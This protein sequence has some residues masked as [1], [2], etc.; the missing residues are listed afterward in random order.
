MESPDE[1][2]LSTPL[3]A[4]PPTLT[5]ELHT[6]PRVSSWEGRG[7]SM[8]ITESTIDPLKGT[9]I[10]LTDAHLRPHKTIGTKG[11]RPDPGSEARLPQHG[12]GMCK[13]A[14]K[15]ARVRAHSLTVRT[16]P[17]G[18]CGVRLR[19]PSLNAYS[20]RNHYDVTIVM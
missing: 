6:F 4:H 17:G 14:A 19:R 2:P 5:H 10:K 20:L 15:C 3:P 12:A 16:Q 11:S 18:G 1:L 8:R 7:G 9:T 13:V